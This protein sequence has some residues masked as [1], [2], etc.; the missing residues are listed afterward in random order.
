LAHGLFAPDPT[1]PCVGASAG[2]S[3]IIT[4]YA[5]A[6]PKVRLG[7][8]WRIWW[9]YFRWL[10]I[11]AVGALVFYMLIQVAGAY[12]QIRGFAGVS[13]LAHLGGMGAGLCAA[14]LDKAWRKSDK[15]AFSSATWV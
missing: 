14:C 1:L 5:I 3:G 11:S 9:V 15:A 7:F 12:F 6:Y 13:Y 8:L 4:Y 10:R 2:V